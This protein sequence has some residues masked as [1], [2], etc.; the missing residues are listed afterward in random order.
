MILYFSQC[1]HVTRDL[2]DPAP[3]VHAVAHVTAETCEWITNDLSAMSTNRNVPSYAEM[4]L[5]YIPVLAHH[6]IRNHHNN[7][8]HMLLRTNTRAC[9]YK[10]PQQDFRQQNKFFLMLL[11]HAPP[12]WLILPKS[13]MLM[14]MSTRPELMSARAPQPCPAYNHIT[15]LR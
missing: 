3:T 4:Y 12:L 13:M 6:R 1:Y 15:F 8:I 5:R 10:R 9:T 7:Q 2:N 14:L 11:T